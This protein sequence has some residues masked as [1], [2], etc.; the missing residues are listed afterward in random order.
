M[1]LIS[2]KQEALQIHK[3]DSISYSPFP[4]P[5]CLEKCT[6]NIK[7]GYEKDILMTLKAFSDKDS[8][9]RK[10]PHKLSGRDTMS[11]DVKS[12]KDNYRMLFYIDNNICKIT[13][14]CTN[15]TH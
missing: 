7:K 14:L 2:K 5:I 4:R 13:N 12:R 11:L 15:E 10:E 8:F 6:M 1:K 9:N 3:K